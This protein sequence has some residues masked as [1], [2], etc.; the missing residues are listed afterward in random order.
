M[1]SYRTYVLAASITLLALSGTARA[2]S[3]DNDGCS[4]S[5]L[6]GDYAFTISGRFSV[7]YREGED[8]AV[9]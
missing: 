8:C 5:T 9:S 6:K 4:N 7:L 1:K 3:D 2:Q